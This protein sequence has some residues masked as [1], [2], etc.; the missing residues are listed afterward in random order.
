MQGL[1]RLKPWYT[2]RLD[3][4]V[5]AA[6]ARGVSPDAFTA[7]GVLGAALA[8]GAIGLGWWPLALVL[9]AVRL[10]G[11]NLD[12]AVARARDVSRPWGFVLN[13]IGD[14]AS[15]LLMFAGLVWLAGRHTGE[16]AS[17]ETGWVLAAALAATLPTVASLAGAGAGARRI[18]GG[19]VGKT[20]RCLL[21]VVACA[22]PSWLVG[23]CAVLVAGSVLTAVLRLAATR[24]ELVGVPGD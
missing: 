24:R 11:A 14:R 23:I 5:R 1:Y 13:E 2:R 12:G 19:P 16:W 20:E 3:R 8:A 21:A 10:A 9:L 6:V 15:D 18:N 17:A 4:V 22:V 7:L